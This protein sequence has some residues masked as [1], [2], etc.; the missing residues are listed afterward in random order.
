MSQQRLGIVGSRTGISEGAVHDFI[1]NLDRDGLV[2]VSGGARG[3]DSWASEE[4]VRLGIASVVHPAEWQRGKLAGKNRNWRLVADCDSVV[5]FWD[6]YSNGTAHAVTA[7]VRMGKR[8]AV[9]SPE[10]VI[11]RAFEEGGTAAA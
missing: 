1:R 10:I 6:G 2:I 8:V 4:A 9:Y 5:A 11:Q 7:A 3:V